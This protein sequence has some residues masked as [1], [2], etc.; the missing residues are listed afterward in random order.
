M[1]KKNLKKKLKG[2]LRLKNETIM[3]ARRIACIK[4]IFSTFCENREKLQKERH[5]T[6]NI[7]EKISGGD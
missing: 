6:Q 2:F 4:R 1:K 7:L 5:M 3:F